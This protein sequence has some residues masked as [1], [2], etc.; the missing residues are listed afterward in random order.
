MPARPSAKTTGDAQLDDS[1]KKAKPGTTYGATNKKML[2]AKA[3]EAITIPATLNLLFM[4]DTDSDLEYFVL[5]KM[6][7]AKIK[8]R[9]WSRKFDEK[10][11]ITFQDP[12][13]L[14]KSCIPLMYL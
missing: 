2:T 5:L 9:S 1:A 11:Y 10:S 4:K 3:T 8:K 12:E 6:F 7:G 14:C 13:F